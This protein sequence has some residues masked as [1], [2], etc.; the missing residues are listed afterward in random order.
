MEAS[1]VLGTL[2]GFWVGFTGFQHYLDAGMGL[3]VVGRFAFSEF[4]SWP[5]ALYIKGPKNTKMC[6]YILDALFVDESF[7]EVHI[8]L[9]LLWPY[10]GVFVG[11]C[12]TT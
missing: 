12:G 9:S 10:G 8:S 2:G 7:P 3:K 6:I 5:I 11:R 1:V 4:T